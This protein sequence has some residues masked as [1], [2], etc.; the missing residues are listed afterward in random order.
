MRII[1]RIPTAKQQGDQ[2]WRAIDK[3][4][5]DV[6]REL[7]RLGY[8][9]VT[10]AVAEPEDDPQVAARLYFTGVGA[11]GIDLVARIALDGKLL[12]IVSGKQSFTAKQALPW[13]R[14][15][16]PRDKTYLP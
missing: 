3:P 12:R 8:A 9:G 16:A 5:R 7:G 2:A 13:L 6:L 14:K 4:T 15:R 11:K 1:K 10:C